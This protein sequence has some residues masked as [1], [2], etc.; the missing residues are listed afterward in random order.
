[1]EI[2]NAKILVVG[3]VQQISDKFKKRD[4]VVEYS[5][6]NPDYKETI[7][8]EMVQDKVELADNFKVGDAVNVHFNL[9]GRASV[10]KDGKTGYFNSLVIWRLTAGEAQPEM[11]QSNVAVAAG[12]EDDDLPF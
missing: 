4:L 5:D 8:F 3:E 9:R 6:S 10:Q 7:K 12:D 1:M 11:A 2:L